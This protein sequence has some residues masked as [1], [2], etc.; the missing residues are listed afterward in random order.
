MVVPYI[1]RQGLT[2]VRL[3]SDFAL[4][5]RWSMFSLE[6]RGCRIRRGRKRQQPLIRHQPLDSK[7]NLVGICPPPPGDGV[8]KGEGE[9]GGGTPYDRLYGDA[10]PEG[11]PLFWLKDKKCYEKMSFLT[12]ECEAMN[13]LEVYGVGTGWGWSPV[14]FRLVPGSRKCRT[15]RHICCQWG[16]SVISCAPRNNYISI[17]IFLRVRLRHPV[18]MKGAYFYYSY[19]KGSRFWPKNVLGRVRGWASG[20]GLPG[21][22]LG[23]S[24]SSRKIS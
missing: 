19:M 4:R 8:G 21:R 20:R 5:N 3:I 6:A 12:R 16:K 7:V 14:H 22:M 11:N 24:S 9:G 18:R 23:S 2:T 17:K 10:P 13:E 1:C 15:V